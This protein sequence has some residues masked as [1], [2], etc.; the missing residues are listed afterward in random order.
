MS[1]DVKGVNSTISPGQSSI[2]YQMDNPV[3]GLR[4]TCSGRRITQ[5]VL[6][7]TVSRVATGRGVNTL[8]LF[9]QY[10]DFERANRFRYINIRIA[11]RLRRFPSVK[12]FLNIDFDTN[13]TLALLACKVESSI[14]VMPRRITRSSFR[15]VTIG[16]SKF[17]IPQYP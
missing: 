12:T 17:H 3:A 14:L 8:G 13:L 4:Q 11:H 16:A 6:K 9:S 5:S 10:E 1:S 15:L 7:V 2:G